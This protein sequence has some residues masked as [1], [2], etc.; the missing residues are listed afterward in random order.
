MAKFHDADTAMAEELYN[1]MNTR[2]KLV[3]LW[4]YSKRF[5]FL[6]AFVIGV[7]G[8]VYALKPTPK[9]EDNL[10]VKFVNASMEDIA[11]E[12][13]RM[14]VDYETYLGDGNTC[15]MAFSNCR[16]STIDETKSGK[17]LGKL[18]FEVTV[19]NIELFVCDEYALNK[20]CST[21]LVL[22]LNTCLDTELLEQVHY[23]LTY[24]ADLE[25]NTVP[26]A[27]DITDTNYVKEMGIQGDGVYLSFAANSPNAEMTK[28]FVTYILSQEIDM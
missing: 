10:R 22:D 26:M 8:I 9:L 4:E 27:I 19:C 13:N 16:I 3:H 5:L 21:G 2:E 24:H 15:E 25:G 7:A 28:Q 23:R 18:A 11:D 17:T 6:I 1:G 14:K 12:N 20:L